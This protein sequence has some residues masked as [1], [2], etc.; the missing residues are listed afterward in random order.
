MKI[1]KLSTAV[2]IG[3]GGLIGI[4]NDLGASE[5]DAGGMQIVH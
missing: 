1:S 2:L 4:T 5:I 3:L